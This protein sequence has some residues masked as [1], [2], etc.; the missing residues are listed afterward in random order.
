VRGGSDGSLAKAER[1][2]SDGSRVSLPFV[3]LEVIRPGEVVV[4]ITN[5]GG[6]YGDPFDRDPA[7]VL[8]DVREGWVSLDAAR[9]AYGVMI[10][11]N[12]PDF[13]VN[14]EVTT[15]LRT[16]ELRGNG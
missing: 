13:I 3:S 16:R 14:E 12:G 2:N 9:N 15:R 11:P 7:R 5:G 4:G 1:I 10:E 6:G 8:A